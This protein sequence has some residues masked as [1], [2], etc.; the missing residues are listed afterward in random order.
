MPHDS[1][2]ERLVEIAEPLKK[3]TINKAEQKEAV[4]AISPFSWLVIHP[5]APATKGKIGKLLVADL[6]RDCE[7]LVKSHK[8]KEADFCINDRLVS[9]R[10]AL[11]SEDGIYTFE[12][13]RNNGSEFLFCLGVSPDTAHAWVFPMNECFEEFTHQ[14]ASESRWMHIR[15]SDRPEWINPKNPPEQ[16]RN[17]SGKLDDALKALCDHLGV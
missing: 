14:H 6:C 17:Q 15:P 8:G 5:V 13:I 2:F 4:W 10:F 3:E 11:L 9:V 12:Q 16:M 7:L 1:K